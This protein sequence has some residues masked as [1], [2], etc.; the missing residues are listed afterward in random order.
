MDWK[1]HRLQSKAPALRRS[2]RLDNP[3]LGRIGYYFVLTLWVGTLTLSIL[4]AF[5]PKALNSS[6][7]YFPDYISVFLLGA[8]HTP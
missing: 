7:V 3:L 4:Q 8:G 2:D 5:V 1:V 6:T